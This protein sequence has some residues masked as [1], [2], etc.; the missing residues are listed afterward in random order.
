MS[1]RATSDDEVLA[2]LGIPIGDARPGELRAA[3]AQIARR[4]HGEGVRV[5]GFVPGDDEVAVPPVLIQIGLALCD[6]TG[7]TIAVVDAN[8]RYPGLGALNR[9][10]AADH[11]ESVFSTRWLRGSLALLSPP[12]VERAGE[13]VPQLARVL[14]DGADLFAHV[15]VDLTG[16]ELLGEHASAAACMDGVALVARAHHTREQDLVDLAHLLPA[17]R[18]LGVLLVG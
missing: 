2:E 13:V 9:G 14:L 4:L 1:A 18:F 8:V 17:G 16:F 12:R 11:D 6:L 10:R 5:V 7:A 15:L 3:C